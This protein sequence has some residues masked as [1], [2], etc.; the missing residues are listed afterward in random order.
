VGI[1]GVLR[2]LGRQLDAAQGY[3]A[4]MIVFVSQSY[5]L[6]SF[7]EAVQLVWPAITFNALALSRSASLPEFAP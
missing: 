2:R 7:T 4:S 3:D 5:R 6:N 1:H